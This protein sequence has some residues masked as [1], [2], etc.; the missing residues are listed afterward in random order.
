MHI[1]K[2]INEKKTI[3]ME[4]WFSLINFARV[5]EEGKTKPLGLYPAC[6]NQA[7]LA[8]VEFY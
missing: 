2:M 8:F 4:Y 6:C 5:D 3:V 1:P 7:L